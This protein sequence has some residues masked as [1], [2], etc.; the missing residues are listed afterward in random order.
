MP[1][2]TVDL[3]DDLAAFV[4]ETLRAGTFASADDLIAHA[5]RQVRAHTP[6]PVGVVEL[7]R[8]GFNEPA[9]MAGLVDKLDKLDRGR[10]P[11]KPR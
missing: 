7:T 10:K 3:P 5:L 9:F 4:D 8:D 1:A 6:A 2:V 11:N